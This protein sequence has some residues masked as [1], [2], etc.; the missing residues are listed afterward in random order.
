MK[1]PY[2][3]FIF[4]FL[5]LIHPI[6]AQRHC[7]TGHLHEERK[8][9]NPSLYKLQEDFKHEVT[10]LAEDKKKSRM[11]ASGEIYSIPVVVHVIYNNT[12]SSNISDAQVLS[13]IDVL[14]EDF[15]RKPG[16]KGFNTHPA[17]AD[18]EIEFCLA[19][20]DPD[21]NFSNGIV[22]RHHPKA[23]WSASIS[24]EILLKSLSYWPSDQYLNIWVCQ[25]EIDYLGYAQFPVGAAQPGP[26]GGSES[27]DG[28]VIDYRAFGREGAAGT[29][30]RGLYK[31]GRTTTHEVGHW[32]GLLHIWGENDFGGCSNDYVDDTPIDEG[33]NQDA[34]CS[35]S[36]DCD[37]DNIYTQDMTNNYLDYSPDVCMNLFTVG[38]KN[39]MRTALETA[40][41]RQS[42]LTSLGCCISSEPVDLPFL[43][44]FQGSALS[45]LKIENPDAGEKWTVTGPGAY[46]KSSQSIV[47]SNDLSP[48]GQADFL[49]T[50]F[51]RLKEEKPSL[52]FDLAYAANASSV[53]DCLVVSYSTSCFTWIP[54][55]T[56]KGS[57]LLS[58]SRI[59]NDF[60]P[61]AHEWKR[62]SVDLE[63]LN[64]VP[65]GRLRFENHSRNINNLYLDNINVYKTSASLIVK[66]YPNP[67]TGILF[68]DVI[69]DEPDNVK[70]E[71]FD[72]LGQKVFEETDYQ[73]TS[74]T[75]EIDLTGLSRGMY[76][77]RV[78]DKKQRASRKILYSY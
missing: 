25:M 21:G 46:D 34:D 41:R 37:G 75:K 42:L 63:P 60:I 73:Q 40:P 53:T 15:R 71:L 38:Q 8:K 61:Q 65:R 44:D 4:F 13:Q 58:T 11:S 70:Y 14:N 69:V 23:T 66:P 3:L 49:E 77:L 55:L 28:V 39:R 67:S 43:E 56:M 9:E 57:D 51:I 17:G 72:L 52:H 16:T 59:T 26:S 19:T 45:L 35:D 1:Q 2:L 36:S 74:Y 33:A 5:I 7:A 18:A 6:T 68:V 31:F 27:L 20:T 50:P 22:R 48:S 54:I 47:L 64:F 24:D 78:S 12:S 62:V 32:L 30:G 76:I 29:G 10:R